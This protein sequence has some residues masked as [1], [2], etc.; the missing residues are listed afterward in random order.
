MKAILSAALAVVLLLSLTSCGRD[1]TDP[2]SLLS[3]E[4]ELSASEGE[5]IF[6]TPELSPAESLSGGPSAGETGPESS[7]AGGVS[8]A[9]G[10][11]S[12]VSSQGQSPA[13]SAAPSQGQASSQVSSRAASGG[14]SSQDAGK[15]HSAAPSDEVRA[16]WITYMELQSM[17]TGKTKSQFRG[18]I[19]AAFDNIAD[20]GLN[21]VFVHVRSHSDAFYDSDLFPW[22]VYCTGTEGKDPGYDPLGIMVEE[23]HDRGLSIEAWVNPYRVKSTADTSKICKSSP[24]YDWL[25]TDKVAVLSG[26]GIFYN[27]ADED[28]IDLIVDGVKE[29]VQNYDVDGIHFDDY[30]YPTTDASFDKDYYDDYRDDGGSMGLAAWRRDNVN[31]MIKRVYKAIKSADSGCRF[32]ISPAGNMTNNYDSLYCDVYTWVQNKGYIDYICP[33]IYFGFQNGSMPYLDVLESY[34][35]MISVSSVEL[36]PGLAAYK[37]GKKDTYAGDGAKE[38]T[39]STDILARQVEAARDAS[40]YGGFAVYSYSALFAPASEVKSGVKAE[41]GN[42]EDLLS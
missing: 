3:S 42:L 10:I 40:R 19:G 5:D 15:T 36:I 24:A 17:L 22:S 9:G 16:V 37:I 18:N 32:G 31:R 27:P 26:N 4:A 2:T 28:V 6:I 38:W 29:I 39:K 20:L 14:E 23:A 33:Q 1:N 13:S 21:T 35:E 8:T 41:R 7:G 30:F 12:A 11:S 25:D 34:D